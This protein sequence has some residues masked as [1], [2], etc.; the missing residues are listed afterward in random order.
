MRIHTLLILVL[1][2]SIPAIGETIEGYPR[3]VDGDSLKFK[4]E[5]KGRRLEGI[6]APE[7]RQLCLDA[8]GE[9][10]PC[11]KK[12]TEHLRKLIGRGKVRCEAKKKGKWGRWISTCFV[13]DNNLNAAMARKGHAVAYSK[14]SKEYIDEEK[15]AQQAKRGIWAGK[16]IVP[17]K[18]RRGERLIEC[19]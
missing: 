7:K 1:T 16:F 4:S 5:E 12:A 9:C 17:E 3:V 19:E 2:I 13:N 11:G 6:D 18:W 10:F 15:E 8:S 14:Y